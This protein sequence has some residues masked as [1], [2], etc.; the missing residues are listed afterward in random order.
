[1]KY[2][3]DPQESWLKQGMM[4]DEEGF[5]EEVAEY[6]G[7]LHTELN[8]QEF[9]GSI[10][11]QPGYYMA[12]YDNVHEVIRKNAPQAVLPEEARNVIRIIELA[13][14]SAKKGTIVPLSR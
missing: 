3:I 1:V 4:P 5:G 8:G 2:G 11:T 7:L 14:E 6:H 13:F 9:H 10:T 12:F